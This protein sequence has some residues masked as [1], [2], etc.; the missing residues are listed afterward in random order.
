M[1]PEEVSYKDLTE[2]STHIADV[3]KGMS[4]LLARIKALEGSTNDIYTTVKGLVDNQ[5][6]LFTAIKRQQLEIKGLKGD[7]PL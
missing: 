2:L 4:A 3:M 1:P 6:Q 5:Q 7:S